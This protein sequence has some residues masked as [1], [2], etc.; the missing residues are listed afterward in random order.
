MTQVKL[1]HFV[2]SFIELHES[3]IIVHSRDFRVVGGQL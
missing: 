1:K 2:L 3:C